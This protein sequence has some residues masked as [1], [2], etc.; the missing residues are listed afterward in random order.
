M[1]VFF[2]IIAIVIYILIFGII[3]NLQVDENGAVLQS[4]TV[5]GSLRGIYFN[6]KSLNKVR[7]LF[8]LY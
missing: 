5:W 1:S 3:D 7:Y 8:Y 6:K 2:P 4:K